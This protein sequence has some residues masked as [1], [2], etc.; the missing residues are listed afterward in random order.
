MAAGR[1]RALFG[2]KATG[3]FAGEGAPAT[4]LPAGV[5]GPCTWLRQVHGAG[6]VVVRRPG[7]H[8][9]VSADAAVTDVPGCTLAVRTADCVPVALLAEGAVGIVHAGWRGLR[10]G[11]VEAAAD[12]VRAL[13]GRG[14]RAVVGPSIG[15]DC[16]EFD[17]PDRFELAARFGAA[18][19]ATTRWGTPGVDLVAGVLEAL[20]SVGVEDVEVE[21]GCT[22]CDPRWFSH[23][24]R[25]DAGRQ[26]S[27]VWLER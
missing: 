23:R 3:D 27:F 4:P 15:A 8:T 25:G 13:G 16:Y 17:G 21:G 7:E 5:P 9:G 11:V 6:V 1:A 10:D 2:D 26:A 12:A 14:V 18:V 20:A 19:L 24:A 22:A